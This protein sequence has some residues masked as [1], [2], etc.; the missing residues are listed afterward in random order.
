MAVRSTRAAIRRAGLGATLTPPTAQ[1]GSLRSQDLRTSGDPVTLDGSII[2]VDPATGAA[3]P[4]NPL[5][6]NSDPN[7][8]R[9][10]SYGLRNPFRFTFRPGTNELWVGDAGYDSTDL[11]IC[12]SLYTAQAHTTPYF[13]YHHNNDV[14]AG[15]TCPTGSSSTAGL[16]F[17]F[18]PT[19]TSYPLA[20]QGALFLADYSRD[21]IWVMKKDANGVP[22]PGLIETF[23][24]GA[25]NPVNLEFG[26]G[27]DLFYVDFGGGTIRRVSTAPRR[28]R[29]ARTTS[30]ISTG[31]R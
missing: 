2:R 15:E 5:A 8:R 20:Y 31:R 19:G 18:S 7:A 4:T 21:C 10:I 1:G 25:A 22:A 3:L 9:I 11:S 26:P 14:V 6:G 16:S 28:R 27:G 17:E 24:A 23:V 12:E 29:P 30:A 13:A